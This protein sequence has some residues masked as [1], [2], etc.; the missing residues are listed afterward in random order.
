MKL[1]CENLKKGDI[2]VTG[3]DEVLIFLAEY[4]N[5]L[6][7]NKPVKGKYNAS[8]WDKMMTVNRP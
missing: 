2:I 1:T 5:L 6:W 3:G 8:G 4:N 7:F